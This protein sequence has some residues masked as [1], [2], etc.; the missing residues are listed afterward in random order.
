MA[1][2]PLLAGE[3]RLQ[4]GR[5]VGLLPVGGD[6]TAALDYQHHRSAG[7]I[8]RLEEF[9]LAA[10]QVQAHPGRSSQPEVSSLSPR[11]TMATS[12]FRAASRALE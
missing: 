6:G 2:P 10:G 7:F 12:A 9:Q 5:N 8:H 3:P 4:N 1:G 11:H